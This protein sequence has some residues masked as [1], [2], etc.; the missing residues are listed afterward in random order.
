MEREYELDG[1]ANGEGSER[2][3]QISG[4]STGVGFVRGGSV[5]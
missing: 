1:G 2:R 5:S 4:A 3:P